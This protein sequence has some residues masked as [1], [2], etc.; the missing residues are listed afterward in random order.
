MFQTKKMIESVDNDNDT[1]F[2]Y[3]ID[4]YTIKD[5][6]DIFSF[7]N[8]NAQE[9][10]DTID[11][12]I[13][14]ATENKNSRLSYFYT[15]AK[16]KL[17]TYL[18]TTG[19]STIN[20]DSVSENLITH[21]NLGETYSTMFF[22]KPGPDATPT[23]YTPESVEYIKSDKNPIFQST[24]HALVNID[25]YYRDTNTSD[26]ISTTRFIST[27][28]TE[29]KNV[30][31]LKLHSIEI[32]Y[33]WYVFDSA[34]GNTIFT[35]D[36]ISVIIDSG[37]YTA[38]E[39]VTTIN[40]AIS[41]AGIEN[42][43][44]TLNTNTNKITI[45]NSSSTSYSIVFYDF[46]LT[47]F[48]NA[49]EN[50][51]LGWQLGYRDSSYTLEAVNSITGSCCLDIYGT[52]YLLL[53]LDD[54]VHNRPTGGIIGSM[55]LSTS[56]SFPPYFSSDLVVE[57]TSSSLA[58]DITIDNTAIPK[59]LTNAQE[60]TINSIASNRQSTNAKQ[61][62]PV[63]TSD[64]IAKIPVTNQNKALT[65]PGVLFVETSNF[66]STNARRY[67]GKVNILKLRTRL[68]DDKGRTIS[69]NGLDWSYTLSVTTLYQT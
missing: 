21:Q 60:Y 33:S 22:H 68:L 32:P 9:I 28:T 38:D 44:L 3:E 13:T 30:I 50:A 34:Y 39:L 63:I 69:L 20:I 53:Q 7:T 1:D 59:R 58:N 8:P 15:K 23:Q 56:C 10:V 12:Y 54:F 26:V 14:Q 62:S 27:L 65:S 5:L 61:S 37:N 29:L 51:N 46:G 64:I 49:L 31:E 24:T 55:Y 41:D 57:D 66:L 40:T 6:M 17:I 16:N 42:L 35:I 48:D 19:S 2:D 47:L 4:N 52:K 11:K 25:S 36:S 18:Q 67:F 45:T 43:T